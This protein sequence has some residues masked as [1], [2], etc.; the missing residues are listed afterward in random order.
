MYVLTNFADC[1]LFADGQMFEVS[2]RFTIPHCP[3]PLTHPDDI[4][5]GH[6]RESSFTGNRDLSLI[7]LDYKQ[8]VS[9]YKP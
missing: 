2:T 9:H 6:Q 3:L 4:C 7:M 5:L 1:T 8:H